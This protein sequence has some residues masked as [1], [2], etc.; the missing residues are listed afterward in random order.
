MSA[1]LLTS[2][3]RAVLSRRSLWLAYATAGYNLLEGLVAIAAGAAA[4]STALIGFG[5]D[6]FVEVSSA[7]VLIWQFRSRVPEDR[8]RLALRLIGASFFALAA[9]VTIDAVRSLLAGGDADASPVGI[10]LAVASLLVMPLLVAAKRRT[11]REL[12]SATVMA[13]STQTMLCTYLSAVLL[14]GLVLNAAWGWS[15][16]D[17]IAA[18]VIA[19]VAVKEGIEAWRGEHCDDCAPLPAIDATSQASSC[20]DGCCTDRKA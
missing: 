15:W 6:S 3:R 10:G 5:L 20:A 4:S 19:V 2:E 9:W 12:G 11:G 7:A 18:L 14:V 16:A 13:D 8:E 17:P 1:S